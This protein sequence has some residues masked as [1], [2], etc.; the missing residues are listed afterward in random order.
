MTDLKL[1]R[2][3]FSKKPNHYRSSGPFISAAKWQIRQQAG[4]I[5]LKS[6]F[7]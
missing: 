7:D 2:R 4:S 3:A 1:L 6:L 5:V